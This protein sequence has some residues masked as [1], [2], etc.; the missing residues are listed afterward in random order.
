MST[1]FIMIFIFIILQIEFTSSQN[2]KTIDEVFQEYNNSSIS[3]EKINS[4]INMTLFLLKTYYPFYN[5]LKDPPQPEG[6]PN[7][8]KKIDIDEL[9]DDLPQDLNLLQFWNYYLKKI[10]S[11]RDLHLSVY[12]NLFE[13]KIENLIYLGVINI[14]TKLNENNELKAYAQLNN[15][16]NENILSL[17][18]DITGLIKENENI[19]IESINGK[20]PFEYIEQLFGDLGVKSPHGLY[21]L[22]DYIFGTGYLLIVPFE[23]EY[24]KDITIKYE[25]GITFNYDYYILDKTKNN[26]KLFYDDEEINQKFLDFFENKKKIFLENTMYFQKCSDITKEFNKINNIKINNKVFNDKKDLSTINWKYQAIINNRLLFQCAYDDTTEQKL[27]VFTLYSFMHVEY[28]Q[29]KEALSVLEN[30]VQ[31]FDTN[32]DPLMIILKINVG[33]NTIGFDILELL[34]PYFSYKWY[35]RMRYGKLFEQYY[36]YLFQNFNPFAEIKTCQNIQDKDKYSNKEHYTEIKYGEYKEYFSKPFLFHS[37]YINEVNE[38]KNKIKYKRKPNEILV[39]TDS[40]SFSFASIFTKSIQFSGSGM[41]IGYNGNP[42]LSES[43]FD[44]GNSPTVVT[45]T[46]GFALISPEIYNEL[47]KTGIGLG[48]LSII[49][50]YYNLDEDKINVPGEFDFM[51]IDE[52][53]SI[54]STYNDEDYNIFKTEAFKFFDKYKTKCFKNNKKFT[55]ISEECKYDDDINAYGGYPCGDNG[56]WVKNKSQC[57]KVGCTV[58]YYLNR[59]NNMCEKDP[60]ANK[61]SEK[62]EDRKTEEHLPIWAIILLSVVPV[63]IITLIILYILKEKQKG[64]FKKRE[65][66]E[67]I[68]KTSFI[69]GNLESE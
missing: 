15:E 68:N 36:P 57:I 59:E 63:I 37:I 48:T 8:Y 61:K 67:E 45:S 44:S 29:H 34:T 38:I 10:S 4:A 35:G 19:P 25:N 18:K 31:L 24:F 7:Y 51:P 52:R 20:N 14:Y 17:W 21:S 42:R 54:Y 26:S 6:L 55:L 12:T 62:S 2:I 60:C 28:E 56:E 43:N 69:E 9:F 22:K 46:E 27:N 33:G 3:T 32:T 58:G 1:N 66:Y 13:L 11:L 47:N 16:L 40:F 65:L 53:S 5:V 49:P 23:L 41:M 50:L 39:F 64:C 30:C